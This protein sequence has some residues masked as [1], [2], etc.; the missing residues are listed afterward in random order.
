[1]WKV[2]KS[3]KALPSDY[4]WGGQLGH[5]IAW[6]AWM[7]WYAKLEQGGLSLIDP[8]A[9]TKSLLVKWAI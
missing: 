9:T 6:V 2:M 8:E 1:M 4:L 7:D 3:I 5:V